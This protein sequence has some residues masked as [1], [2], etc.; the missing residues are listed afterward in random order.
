[1]ILFLID[2]SLHF[3][4]S[5]HTLYTNLTN[6]S[7]LYNN[8]RLQPTSPHYQLRIRGIPQ[9]EPQSYHNQMKFGFRAK[10]VNP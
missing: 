6:F 10:L 8:K 9:A 3:M 1:M 7:L 4:Y 5:I 2:K